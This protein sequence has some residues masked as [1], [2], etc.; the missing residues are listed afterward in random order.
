VIRRF[1]RPN[2]D[3]GNSGL[4]MAIGAFKQGGGP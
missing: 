1:D 4:E 3:L 2:L